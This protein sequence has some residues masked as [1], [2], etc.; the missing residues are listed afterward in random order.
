MPRALPLC[1]YNYYYHSD[2]PG[3]K[4]P[5]TLPGPG[6]EGCSQGGGL[7]LLLWGRF[8]P[9]QPLSQAPTCSRGASLTPQAHAHKMIERALGLNTS[10]SQQGQGGT[11]QTSEVKLPTR[12]TPDSLREAEAGSVL[13][14]AVAH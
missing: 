4:N 11:G 6:H 14:G 13:D 9:A 2:R 5:A 10:R 12:R 3:T 1:Y 8:Q 7:S